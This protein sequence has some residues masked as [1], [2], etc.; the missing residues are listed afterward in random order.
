M[1]LHLIYQ[2]TAAFWWRARAADS[3][4]YAVSRSHSNWS[5]SN[6]QYSLRVTP[7]LTFAKYRKPLDT[8][9]TCWRLGRMPVVRSGTFPSFIW[10]AGTQPETRREPSTALIGRAFSSAVDYIFNQMPAQGRSTIVA[11]LAASMTGAYGHTSVNVKTDSRRPWLSPLTT[12]FWYFQA[13]NVARM[14]LFYTEALSSTT[15]HQVN[16][17]IQET[18]GRTSVQPYQSIPI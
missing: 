17:A 4:S 9:P 16:A 13:D 15:V 5:L 1:Y 7:L 11:S 18:R 3:M 2:D 10:C 12:L 8:F 6:T 14:K